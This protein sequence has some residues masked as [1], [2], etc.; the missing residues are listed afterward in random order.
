MTVAACA[1][2]FGVLE[3]ILGLGLLTVNPFASVPTSPS[4]FVTVTFL[5]GT[6]ASSKLKVH[7]MLVPEPFTTTLV[8]IMSGPAV[9]L[10]S[11][12]SAPGSKL[13]PAR[14]VML[15]FQ[16]RAPVFG[17][18]AVTVGAGAAEAGGRRTESARKKMSATNTTRR[19]AGGLGA[20]KPA[21]FFRALPAPYLCPG[22]GLLSG[23]ITVVLR[24]PPIKC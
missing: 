18:I 16:P 15:T 2:V 8:A 22:T 14:L 7:V 24:L 3:V 11:L 9:L 21:R 10:T 1:P 23:K 12:T 17:V 4:G 6:G 20:W 5:L 19:T 13:D